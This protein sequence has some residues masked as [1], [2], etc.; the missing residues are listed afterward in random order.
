MRRL[1]FRMLLALT[2][3]AAAPA[4]AAQ[5]AVPAEPPVDL[6][7]G[8]VQD[9]TGTLSATDLARVEEAADALFDAH[10]TA[11]FV[12]VVDRFTGPADGPAWANASAQLSGLGGDD[13]LLAVATGDRQLAYS[14]D[15]D[16]PLS[17]DRIDAVVDDTLVPALRDD[18]WAGG[19]VAFAD[20]VDEALDPGPP[21]L[22]LIGGAVVVAVLA[23]FGVRAGIRAARARR[24]AQADEAELDRLEAR[25]DALLVE[26]DDSVRTSTQEL[27]FAAAQ[28]GDDTTA[29]FQSTL[30]GARDLVTQAFEKMRLVDDE[31]AETPAERRALLESIIALCTQADAALD[32]QADAFDDLRALEREAPRLREELAAAQPDV[33]ARIAAARAIEADIRSRYGDAALASVEGSVEQADRLDAF[34]AV[35]LGRAEQSLR[36]GQPG[37]AAVRVRSAQ[38]ALGQVDELLTGVVSLTESLSA[39]AVRL[40]AAIADTRADIAAA[41]QAVL[42]DTADAVELDAAADAAERAIADAEHLPPPDAL[43]AVDAAD[44]ELTA[45]SS[46]VLG[47]SADRDRALAEWERA[48][49]TAREAI[50]RT[51][52]FID[53][54]RG[55]IGPRARTRLT[56]AE[57]RYGAALAHAA[58]DDPLAATTAARQ[59][60][61]QAGR[62][63]DIARDD[64]RRDDPLPPSY[65]DAGDRA[66]FSGGILDGLFGGWGSGSSGG[67]SRSGWSSSS[68]SSWRSS[69][70]R[71]S[72]SRRSSSRSSSS[73]SRRSGGSGSSSR[74]SGG[75]RF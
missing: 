62:A 8:Y 1:W 38:Q 13:I 45:V 12:V 49:A 24:A 6:A 30:T 4:A 7:G 57:S 16:F 26:L 29:P 10:G 53:T 35:E 11:L 44:A 43:T 59:A 34:A 39:A 60:A 72:S 56:A 48:I 22:L 42:D 9:T 50:L 69:S 71:S 27:S 74:R 52:G 31:E 19:V 36:D 23:G 55:I 47:R 73:S 63:L 2:F 46:R 3:S 37:V 28:F 41:R 70:S 66:A 33:S 17:N 67:G 40:A 65:D 21:W 32:A 51:R 61:A 25:A 18:D 75:R 15:D 5:T 54:R 58:V 20:G 68:R 64:V 14:V